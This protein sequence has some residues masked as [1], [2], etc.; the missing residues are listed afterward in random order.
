MAGVQIDSNGY[1][2]LQILATN[3]TVKF[4]PIN[5]TGNEC[6]AK[7]FLVQPNKK[8]LDVGQALVGLGF[9]RTAP[10]TQEIDLKAKT[11]FVRYYKQLKSSESRAKSLRKGQWSSLPENWLRWFLRTQIDKFVFNLKTL[12]MK[13][14][15][16][17]R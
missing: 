12:V 7:V 2:W 4:L 17:V 10:L 1:S 9:A 3:K 16:L 5:N 13:L 14:P 11:G 8:D 6:Q 15:A